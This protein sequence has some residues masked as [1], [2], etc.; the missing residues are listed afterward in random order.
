M[1][2]PPDVFVCPVEPLIL[3]PFESMSK[4][5]VDVV[6]FSAFGSFGI[7]KL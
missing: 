4:F 7:K 1:Y 2:V 3:K 5:A 6:V